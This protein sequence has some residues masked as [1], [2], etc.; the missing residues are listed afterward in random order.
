MSFFDTL[1]GTHLVA[2]LPKDTTSAHFSNAQLRRLYES[3]CVGNTPNTPAH[4]ADLAEMIYAFPSEEALVANPMVRQMHRD[5]LGPFIA[6][7]LEMKKAQSS[8][9][10]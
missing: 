8:A 10:R 1:F 2:P 9:A 3:F 4:I 6:E 7:V 5:G